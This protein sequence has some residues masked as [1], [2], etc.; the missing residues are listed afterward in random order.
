MLRSGEMLQRV[1]V[2]DAGTLHDADTP[3]DFSALLAYHNSQLVR[4]VVSV[5]LNREYAF[6][7]SQVAMLLMLVDETH[8]VRTAGQRMQL[9]YTGCW[10]MIR[11]LESQLNHPLIQRAQGGA[12]G[13][14]SWLTEDGL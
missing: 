2:E 7:D 6:F 14:Q 3:E 11:T 8:S 13:S 1:E 10:N 9:S 5:S 4:P 12:K